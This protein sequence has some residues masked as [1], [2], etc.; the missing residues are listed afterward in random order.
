MILDREKGKEGGERMGGERERERQRQRDR[1][2]ERK[3]EW[4]IDAREKYQLAA[5]CTCPSWGSKL[6]P[7]YVP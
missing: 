5:S 6:Q 1:E 2:R 7:R 3:R 4:S